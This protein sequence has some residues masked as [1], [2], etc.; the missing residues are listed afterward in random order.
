MPH[1]DGELCICG[2]VFVAHEHLRRGLDCSLCDPGRCPSFV[3]TNSWR[4]VLETRRRRRR[5]PGDGTTASRGPQLVG[6]V[7]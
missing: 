6:L 3:S 1:R 2:H 5:R 7:G 4:A